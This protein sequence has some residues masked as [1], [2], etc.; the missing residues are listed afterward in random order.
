MPYREFLGQDTDSEWRLFAGWKFRIFT[1]QGIAYIWNHEQRQFFFGVNQ[2][3]KY[4]PAYPAEIFDYL[5]TLIPSKGTAWDCGTGNGQV[6]RELAKSFDE[7]YATD[8]SQAQIDRALPAA[9]IHYLVQAAL[10]QCDSVF[11]I[12]ILSRLFIT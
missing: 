4:R 11:F 12:N 1:K 5:N 9:D 6:A 7:V 8:I 2:Y 10:W 3:A